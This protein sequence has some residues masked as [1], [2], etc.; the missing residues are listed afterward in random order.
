MLI[1]IDT[2]KEDTEE[3]AFLA[4]A[5]AAGILDCGSVEMLNKRVGDTLLVECVRTGT[6]FDGEE[7]TAWQSM[8]S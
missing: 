6:S 2:R 3:H 8:C 1:K 5:V 7:R 4:K